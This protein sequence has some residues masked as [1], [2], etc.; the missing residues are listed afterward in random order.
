[1]QIDFFEE[2]PTEE[3]LNKLRLVYWS[4]LVYVASH[5][6]KEFKKIE[7]NI[8]KINKKVRVG[9][10]PILKI[11]EG[12]WLSAFSRRSALKRIMYELKI[13]KKKKLIVLWDSELPML[14]PSL[15]ILQLF[16]Y[17]RNKRLIYNFL[18]NAHRYGIKI[19]IAENKPKLSKKFG[20]KKILMAYSSDFKIAPIKALLNKISSGKKFKDRLEIGLGCI[21]SG[22]LRIEPI[23]KPGK[24]ER[25]LKIC[26]KFGIKKIVI[27]RL[28]GLNKQYVRVLK[29][30]I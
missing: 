18:N 9:Y 21:A 3:N 16:N 29:K 25:D 15:F 20:D 5:S 26:K 8:K 24:L 27:F 1:M 10:W 14:N 22:I 2:F 4:C 6:L 17:T 28:G 11:K 23:L 12:Y 13:K 19:A 7:K 30:Y